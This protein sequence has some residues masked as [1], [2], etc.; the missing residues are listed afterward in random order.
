M[1]QKEKEGKSKETFYD[2]VKVN[3]REKAKALKIPE[4]FH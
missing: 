2:T 3:S 1:A 4:I